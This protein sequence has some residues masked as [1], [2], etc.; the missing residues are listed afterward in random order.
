MNH[1]CNYKYHWTIRWLSG[2]VQIRFSRRFK[3]RNLILGYLC[4][5]Y[6]VIFQRGDIKRPALSAD[7]RAYNFPTTRFSLKETASHT[8]ISR[9]TWW[10]PGRAGRASAEATSPLAAYPANKIQYYC[11]THILL[12]SLWIFTWP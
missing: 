10:K 4:A 5:Q 7:S 8:G 9:P 11:V 12:P 1:L 6:N 2:R 3:L